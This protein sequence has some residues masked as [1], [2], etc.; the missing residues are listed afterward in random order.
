MWLPKGCRR[1]QCDAIIDS[2]GKDGCGIY[3]CGRILTPNLSWPPTHNRSARK[4]TR[5]EIW[6]REI[7]CRRNTVWLIL[8]FS[9]ILHTIARYDRCTMPRQKI[10]LDPYQGKWLLG[11]AW[12]RDLQ[13][14]DM[15]RQGGG[16]G[17]N[18][19]HTLR[20][21]QAVTCQ[22]SRS[23]WHLHSV[24][25]TNVRVTSVLGSTA[26]ASQLPSSDSEP[27]RSARLVVSFLYRRPQHIQRNSSSLALFHR[28]I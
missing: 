1:H 28:P 15:P 19:I 13:G 20:E 5:T 4:F 2:G 14:D 9:A 24:E 7:N 3:D 27:A 23:T 22:V 17:R 11:W 12:S 21:A 26:L 10:G 18:K 16:L 25:P 6:K 8:S